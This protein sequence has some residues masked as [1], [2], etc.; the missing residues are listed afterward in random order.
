MQWLLT[1]RVH[2]YRKRYRGSGHVW[3]GRFKAFPIE[4][5]EHLLTMLR[6]VERNALRGAGRAGRGLAL[7]AAC[8]C[9][10]HQGRCPGWSLARYRVQPAGWNWSKRRIA[11]QS[12][13]PCAQCGPWRTI[14]RGRMGRPGGGAGGPGI[15]PAAPGRPRRASAADTGQSDLFTGNVFW[16]SRFGPATMSAR[17]S[18][19]K[20]S[21]KIGR[22]SA[23]CRSETRS[24]EAVWSVVSH[25]SPTSSIHVPR[26]EPT[27]AIHRE[28]KREWRRGD[29]AEG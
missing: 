9:G 8:R 18:A 25:A 10:S 7:M 19:G 24:G 16:M 29:H 28:R 13:R 17:A 5:D 22:P 11:K 27:E 15:Q 4:Q 2:G 20:A 14:R 3:Q 21:T 6:Y 1:A 12:L 26:F 23:V